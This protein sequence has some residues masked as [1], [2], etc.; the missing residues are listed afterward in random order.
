MP[1]L[2]LIQD[3]LSAPEPL[4]DNDNTR[5]ILRDFYIFPH[6]FSV[7]LPAFYNTQKPPHP[8]DDNQKFP[9]AHPDT[10][11]IWMDFRTS[12]SPDLPETVGQIYQVSETLSGCFPQ[13][14][15]TRLPMLLRQILH[16]IP[17]VQ[18]VQLPAELHPQVSLH[19]CLATLYRTLPELHISYR[20]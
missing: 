5:K 3:L 15:E 11:N 13:H 2:S 10:A 1:L 16:G 4:P 17:S 12:Y 7:L 14:P 19:H 8:S 6:C 18:T 9:A 20:W